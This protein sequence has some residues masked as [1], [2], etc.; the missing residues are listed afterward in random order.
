MTEI[1]KKIPVRFSL[2]ERDLILENTFF[3]DPGLTDRLK[4]SIVKSKSILVH[5]SLSELDELLG[6]IAAESN[7]MEDKKLQNAFDKIYD[8]LSDLLESHI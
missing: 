1:D 4:V 7:H 3:I 8:R 2:K 6:F 5:Y